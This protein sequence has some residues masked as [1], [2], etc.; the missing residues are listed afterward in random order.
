MERLARQVILGHL[1]LELD[2]VGTVSNR[3]LPSFESPV[4]RSIPRRLTVRLRARTPIDDEK[5][6]ARRSPSCS[7]EQ[8]GKRHQH[9]AHRSFQRWKKACQR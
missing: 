4:L 1:A 9:Q 3:G 6:P 8:H 7:T 2:A 5:T